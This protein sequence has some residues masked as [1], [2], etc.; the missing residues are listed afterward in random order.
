MQ[1]STM[2]VEFI[3][4]PIIQ[5][6]FI[7]VLSNDW[8]TQSFWLWN[9]HSYVETQCF[10]D[11]VQQLEGR[12]HLVHAFSDLS[13]WPA[14]HYSGACG[15]AEWNHGRWTWG[16]KAWCI[17]ARLQVFTWLGLWGNKKKDQHV[18]TE[19]MGSSD[20]GSLRRTHSI[21][22]A[23][24]VSHETELNRDAGFV[25]TAELGRQV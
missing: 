19:K 22:E 2:K 25:K 6:I 5:T 10:C 3:S 20:L 23:Q 17:L 11:K 14:G 4:V 9:K 21:L 8:Q 1:W 24:S 16:R 15:K 12:I 18:D 7:I 13:P